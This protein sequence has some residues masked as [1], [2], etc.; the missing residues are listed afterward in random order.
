MAKLVN[1]FF[2]S[3]R[4]GDAQIADIAGLKSMSKVNVLELGT[5][6]ESIPRTFFPLNVLF[7]GDT[8]RKN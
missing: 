4:P 8:D 5:V 1:P 7:H 2:C 6:S 3:F